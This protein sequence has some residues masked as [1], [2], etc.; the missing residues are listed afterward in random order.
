MIAQTFPEI[1]DP[2]VARCI[3]HLSG[4]KRCTPNI[5]GVTSFYSER[6]LFTGFD[7][8]ALMAWYE[9]VISA[10]RQAAIPAL[11]KIHHSRFI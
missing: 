6:R 7:M 8:A 2:K 9:T 5:K 3:G 10:M 4:Q 11:A 1:E